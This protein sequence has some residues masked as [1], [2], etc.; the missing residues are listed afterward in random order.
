MVPRSLL[1]CS[2]RRPNLV[3]RPQPFRLL[4]SGSEKQPSP[5]ATS[6]KPPRSWL[7]RKLEKSPAAKNA[8]LTLAKLLGYGSSRQISARRSFAMYEQLCVITPDE[9]RAFWQDECHLPPTFQSWFTV[10]NLHVWLL[11][12]RLRALP[13]PHGKIYIQA[14]IDHF[15]L[16]IEDRVRA[17]LQPATPESPTTTSAS[18]TGPY[19]PPSSFYT[20]ANPTDGRSRPKGRAPERLVGQQ[21]KIFRE[22]WAG[23][24][25]SFDIALL[26]GDEEMAAAVWR[27]F[28]GGR[29][30]RGIVYPSG[31]NPQTPYF[32]RSVNLVGG[33]VEKVKKIDERGLEVEEARDDGSG[34]H[35]YLPNEAD[36]YVAYPELMATLVAYMRRE[37]VRLQQ[38]PDEAFIG[39]RPGKEG[40]GLQEM[41]FGRVRATPLFE[42]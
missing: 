28:L 36:K 40:G 30:A 19:T 31:Q 14:L 3:L 42:S 2:L 20:I 33:E 27:N 17:I 38:V 5:P 32:R 16:D 25:M 34:V 1:L 9:D 15:F 18:L 29:G 10:V 35:D 23:M 41:R 8:F 37:L 22:Q 24:G 26:T 12:V 4:T 13:P 21:L 39:I 7:T 11:T 6:Q